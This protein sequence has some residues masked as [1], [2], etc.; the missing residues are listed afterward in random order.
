M[1]PQYLSNTIVWVKL[2]VRAQVSLIGHRRVTTH[3]MYD[4]VNVRRLSFMDPHMTSTNITAVMLNVRRPH[5]YNSVS[6]G[7]QYTQLP[8]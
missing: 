4:T 3:V 2:D 6:F 7:I 5:R 1:Q 8:N